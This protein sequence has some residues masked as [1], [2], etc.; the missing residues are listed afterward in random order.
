[1]FSSALDTAP[2]L[3]PP[4]ATAVRPSVKHF[5]D[6]SKVQ[7]RGE[8]LGDLLARSAVPLRVLS[9]RRS[10]CRRTKVVRAHDRCTRRARSFFARNSPRTGGRVRGVRNA[11]DSHRLPQ[12]RSKSA[13][14]T[15]RDGRPLLRAAAAVCANSRRMR[16][17]SC[18][19]V[20]NTAVTPSEDAR[21]TSALDAAPQVGRRVD[22]VDTSCNGRS[23]SRL[24]F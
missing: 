11:D 9:R 2:Q 18:A 22:T 15:P 21:F 5:L 7:E 14:Q 3:S 16:P 10:S 4:R 1:M 23:T 6:Q 13:S 12:I 24:T 8:A 19:G 20:G 17:P